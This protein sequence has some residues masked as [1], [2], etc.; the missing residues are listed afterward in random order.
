MKEYTW[1]WRKGLK[2][3]SMAILLTVIAVLAA[4]GPGALA[5]STVTFSASDDSHVREDDPYD[6]F[7]NNTTMYVRSY[8]PCWFCSTRNRRTFIRFDVS[9]LPAGTTIVSA[10]LKL[11]MDDSPGQNRT[12]EARRVLENWNEAAINW[13]NLPAKFL[14]GQ[15]CSCPGRIEEEPMKRRNW[16]GLIW[17]ALLLPVL[18]AA[19]CLALFSPVQAQEPPPDRPDAPPGAP[20]QPSTRPGPP[21]SEKGGQTG[22]SKRDDTGYAAACS[23]VHGFALNWGYRPEPRLPVRLGGSDWQ[24]DRV[25]DDNGYYASNCLGLGIGLLN[26]AAP[27]GLHPL[28]G[29]VAIRL[30]YHENLEVNLGLY[31][32]EL[33]PSLEINPSMKVSSPQVRPGEPLTYIITLTNTLGST[34]DRALG[35]L[36]ITD[37]LP[38]PVLPVTITTTTGNVEIWGS[39]LTADVGV[40]PP[41]QVVVVTITGWVRENWVLLPVI[42]NRASIIAHGHVTVQTAPVSTEVLR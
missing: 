12:Y 7:G 8:R 34:P 35:N 29:D 19:L 32:G 25:T 21:H 37:L 20:G 1:T 15:V 13:Y 26:L 4:S 5:D 28:A 39:L 10:Q 6:E 33:P 3:I 24:A 23:T 36:M 22:P 18:V 40:L 17:P 9:S 38:E 16:P 41:G 14:P 31:G 11:Y 30:G 27:P 42:I 2:F